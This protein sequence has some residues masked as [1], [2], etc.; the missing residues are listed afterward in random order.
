[1]EYCAH[2]CGRIDH[3]GPC[4]R[5]TDEASERLIAETSLHCPSCQT[6]VVKEEG[7]NHMTCRCQHEFCYVCGESIPRDSHG[8]QA[9]ELHFAPNSYSHVGVQG[10][11]QQFG[12]VP[13][14]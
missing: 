3:D 5:S 7:C 6:P 2:G 8:R 9:T 14:L 4:E 11:C 13:T 10:G 1:M 12:D